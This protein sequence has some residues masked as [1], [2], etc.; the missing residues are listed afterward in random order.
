[1]KL[2][3]IIS[4]CVLIVSVAGFMLITGCAG[5]G[6]YESAVKHW[7]YNMAQEGWSQ[8]LGEKPVKE[9]PDSKTAPPV[10]NAVLDKYRSRIKGWQDQ[11]IMSGWSE[12]LAKKITSTTLALSSYEGSSYAWLSPNAFLYNSMRGDCFEIAAQMLATF[13]FLEFP[14]ENRCRV[15]LPLYTPIVNH[16]VFRYE[17]PE[18][19][20]HQVETTPTLTTWFEKY[21][22]MKVIEFDDKRIWR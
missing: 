8:T 20:W 3:T 4:V 13:I 19:V 21:F 12:N 16:A 17:W 22:Y 18:G 10:A 11:I 6:P 2:K 1:M 5:A 14:H 15:V 9:Y 7:Q